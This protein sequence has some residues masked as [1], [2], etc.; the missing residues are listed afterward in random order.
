MSCLVLIHACKEL[1][2]YQNSSSVRGCWWCWCCRLDL[3]S[4]R[5]AD[6]RIWS[7]V[8]MGCG[9]SRS[10][11]IEPRYHESR[12]TES[13][14]LTD[15]EI[16]QLTGTAT[17]SAHKPTGG[18]DS[19]NTAATA[20]QNHQTLERHEHH[21][22]SCERVLMNLYSTFPYI[23]YITFDNLMTELWYWLK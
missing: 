15:T 18:T 10:A 2:M 1:V 16:T 17:A 22:T 9:G 14:W 3:I 5:D 11:A 13:T 4:A 6:L 7:R 8:S 12:D 21:L 20:G 23:Q 19:D